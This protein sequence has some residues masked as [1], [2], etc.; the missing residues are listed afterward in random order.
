MSLLLESI[1]LLNGEF[2]NVSY[3]EQRMNRSLKD[4]CGF[5][6]HF[7]LDEFLNKVEGPKDGLYKC[8]LVYDEDSKDIE[9][10]KYTPR[11][12]GSLLVVEHD[13]I[14]Y[15]YKYTDRTLIDRLFDRRGSNDDILIVRQGIVTDTSYAN[16]AFRKG[17]RWYTPWSPLLK[18]TMRAYLLERNIIQEEEI[19]LEDVETFETFRLMNAMIGF[20]SDESPVAN[21]IF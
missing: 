13:R 16:I 17:K 8:R 21:I 15:N 18:G 20:E 7:D 12:V 1:K 6:G 14:I 9:F 5:I 4:L 19:R 10:L 3:H 2:M 11:S